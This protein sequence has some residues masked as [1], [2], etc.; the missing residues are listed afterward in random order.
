M[1]KSCIQLKP[2]TKRVVSDTPPPAPP[3]VGHEVWLGAAG[4]WRRRTR[5]TLAGLT[6]EKASLPQSWRVLEKLPGS[7][8][9]GNVP[10]HHEGFVLGASSRG[11]WEGRKV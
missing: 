6:P 7:R 4:H 3:S 1:P 2:T 9:H 11:G 8:R 10:A 5:P